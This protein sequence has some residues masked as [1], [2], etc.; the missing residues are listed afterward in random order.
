MVVF[1]SRNWIASSFTRYRDELA[2]ACRSLRIRKVLV[3]GDAGPETDH[4]ST[5]VEATGILAPDAASRWL[6]QA[7]AGF[8]SCPVHCLAKSGMFA[9]YTA[10]GLLPVVAREGVNDDELVVGSTMLAATGLSEKI[11]FEQIARIST[12]A[13]AWYASHNLWETASSYYDQLVRLTNYP[14]PTLSR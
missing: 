2:H 6:E 11:P 1:G 10:H 9:A 13:H 4:F 3:I 12:G 7:R 8:T 14:E 5:P